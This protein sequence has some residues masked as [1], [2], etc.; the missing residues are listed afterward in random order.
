MVAEASEVSTRM[1]LHFS[2]QIAMEKGSASWVGPAMIP[3]EERGEYGPPSFFIGIA[4]CRTLEEERGKWHPKASNMAPKSIQNHAF[5]DPKGS[6]CL[7]AAVAA[8]RMSRTLASRC[9]GPTS[10]DLSVSFV[11]APD[12]V[13]Q[14]Q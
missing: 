13:S 11:S 4:I 14:A 12:S 9:V 1:V 3:P 5:F 8:I 2:R 6:M 7:S 10:S